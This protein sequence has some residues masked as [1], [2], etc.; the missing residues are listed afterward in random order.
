VQ[1]AKLKDIVLRKAE[2]DPMIVGDRELNRQS[3]RVDRSVKSVG[4]IIATRARI[5]DIQPEIEDRFF[6]FF[7]CNPLKK[8]YFHQG[9]PNKTK[10]FCLHFLGFIWIF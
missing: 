7:R 9:A 4:P 3:V 1:L 2:T 8:A 5:V 10:P 6:Y